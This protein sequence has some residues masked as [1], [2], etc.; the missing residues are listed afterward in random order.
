ME[1]L[2]SAFGYVALLGIAWILGTRRTPICYRPVV[3]GTLLQLGLASLI[4]LTQ[5]REHVF[6]LVSSLTNGLQA[7]A[8]KANESLLFIGIS[9]PQFQQAY[10]PVLALE[11]AAILVFVASLSRILYHYRIL[12]A[13]ISVASRVSAGPSDSRSTSPVMLL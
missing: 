9:N 2:H 4:L 8:L 10:G 1:T 3:V 6:V 11:I 7:T 12:P 5:L 13:V